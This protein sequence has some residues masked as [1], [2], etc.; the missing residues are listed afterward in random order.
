M[1][2]LNTLKMLNESWQAKCER[3]EAA[4]VNLAHIIRTLDDSPGLSPEDVRTIRDII[5]H[6]QGRQRAT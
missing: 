1:W 6:A 4:D 2:D 3:E 5:K